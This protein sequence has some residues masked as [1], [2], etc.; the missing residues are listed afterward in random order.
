MKTA[1][2]YSANIYPAGKYWLHFRMFDEHQRA[3]TVTEFRLKRPNRPVAKPAL[4]INKQEEIDSKSKVFQT[5]PAVL[6]DSSLLPS[7]MTV[8]VFTFPSWRLQAFV[9]EATPRCQHVCQ[10]L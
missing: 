3:E 9:R 10:L 4:W 8:D 7:C 6:F 2:S 5:P 1:L